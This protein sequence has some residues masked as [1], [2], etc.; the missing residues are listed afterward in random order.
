[1][2]ANNR[3]KNNAQR[4]SQRHQKN[5]YEPLPQRTW[6]FTQSHKNFHTSEHS[7]VVMGTDI[8]SECGVF[9]DKVDVWRL[10]G[11]AT[12]IGS[13]GMGLASRGFTGGSEP[14][15]PDPAFPGKPLGRQSFLH[16]A[17]N[18]AE[19]MSRISPTRA[20]RPSIK[21]REAHQQVKGSRASDPSMYCG[22][23]V[24]LSVVT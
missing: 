17:S 14:A 21:T 9:G 19:T 16:G 11:D 22:Q 13:R 4:I 18:L 23:K 1:M 20:Q 12:C 24:S 15:R 6:V 10:R 8:M 7:F 2:Q 3:Q 5:P